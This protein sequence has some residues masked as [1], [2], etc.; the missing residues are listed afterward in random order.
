M[1]LWDVRLAGQFL[2]LSLVASITACAP[3]SQNN[4][5]HVREERKVRVMGVEETWQLVWQGKQS[6][7]CGPD[8]VYMAITCPCAGFA[9]AEYGDLWLVRKQGNRE[10]ERMDLRP[11]FGQSDYPEAEKVAGK[12]YVQRWPTKES[13]FDREGRSDPKLVAEIMQRPAPTIMK[14][15]DYDHD[16]NATEFL[17]QVGTLPCGKLQ[18]AAVGVSMKEPHL[19]AFTPKGS[20][21]APLIMPLNAWQ[22]LLKGGDPSTVPTWACGDHGSESRSE[23]I[24]S[25]KNGDISAEDR[26]SPC[27]S[28]N[29][30]G[31]PPKKSD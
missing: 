9:Y 3:S 2:L 27:P 16:G 31:E 6:T 24:V 15:A 18:F 14:L 26:E 13:D 7:V 17:I 21:T 5:Q 30:A 10:I 28:D 19:H 20:Q 12:A 22:V 25:A 4:N 8:E 23:L 1:R 29:P 11:L